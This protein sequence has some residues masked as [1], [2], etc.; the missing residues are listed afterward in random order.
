MSEEREFCEV[1]ENL[2]KECLKAV[3]QKVIYGF[4]FQIQT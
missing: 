1:D 3:K 2:F 4:R